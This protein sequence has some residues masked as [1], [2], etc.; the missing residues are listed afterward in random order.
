MDSIVYESKPALYT[1]KFNKNIAY[2][3]FQTPKPW[4]SDSKTLPPKLP[5]EA[6]E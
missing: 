6:K 3:D 1:R 4:L 5:G 2:D